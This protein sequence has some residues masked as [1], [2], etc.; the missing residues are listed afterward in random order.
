MF[1]KKVRRQDQPDGSLGAPTNHWNLLVE[2]WYMLR[3]LLKK[4]EKELT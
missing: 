4:Q 3:E 1:Y 2:V